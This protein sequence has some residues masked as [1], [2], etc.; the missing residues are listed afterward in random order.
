[1]KI[2]FKILVLPALFTAI[3]GNTQIQMGNDI[4]GEAANNSSGWAV[5]MPDGLT[6]AIGAPSNDEVASGAGHVRVF[7]WNG[8]SWI[9]KGEDLDGRTSSEKVGTDVS[10]PN[11]NTVGIGVPGAALSTGRVEVHSWNGS[12]WVQKGDDIVGPSVGE[13][14]GYA[15][16]MP[17]ENTIAIGTQGGSTW[18]QNLAGKVLIYIWN[19][20]DWVQKGSQIIGEHTDDRFGYDVSMPNSNT[21]AISTPFNDDSGTDAGHVRVFQWNGTDWT[22]KGTDI[23][24]A[25]A[26]DNFGWA[27]SMPDENT[28]AVGAPSEDGNGLFNGGSVRVFN[29]NGTS[30]E[31]KGSPVYG[32]AVGDAFGFSVSMPSASTFGAGARY[33][34]NSFNVAGSASVYSWNGSNWNKNGNTMD[35][36][37]QDNE[38]GWA[39][40]MG[41]ENTIAIGSIKNKGNGNDAGHVRLYQFDGTTGMNEYN[42]SAGTL[43]YPNPS[44][45]EINFEL[46]K[47]GNWE[48]HSVHGK[49]MLH[50]EAKMGLNTIATQLPAGI[51][52]FS[53]QETFERIIIE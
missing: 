21:V 26:G 13:R 34:S 30:W 3:Y 20:T 52:L 31:Q 37:G 28:I 6:V 53:C 39:V 12:S 49:L 2:N 36:E 11:V 32:E 25:A 17:D 18:S 35:G 51:Y 4:D 14:F 10:M 1:M 27:I 9:Q 8:T 22:P 38:S 50:G 44:T 16:S 19:G 42:Q 43:I 7:E 41:D 23:D 5:S 24:G 29:W 46:K 45:G 33:S 40:S 48:L 47:V 15:I